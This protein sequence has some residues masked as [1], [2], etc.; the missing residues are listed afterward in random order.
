MPVPE[1][2]V[3]GTIHTLDPA[4]PRAGA[5]LLR[6]GRIACVGTEG[7]C[8]ARA[9][10][11]ARR[12]ELGGGS[13]I[14]GLADAHGHVLWLGRAAFEVSCEGSASAE[15]CAALVAARAA[16]TAEGRWIV[17]RGWD[18][19]RWPGAAFPD[20]A[21]LSRAAP[22]HPAFLTRVDGH[23]AWVNR[24]ALEAA[25]IAPGT[26]DPP[27][28][29]IGRD[30]AGRPDG[31]LIDAAMDLVRA[32]LPRPA[33]AELEEGLLAG[34]RAVAA[35]GL[36]SVHDAGCAPEVLDAY[37]RLAAAD[38]LPVRVYA[39]IDGMVPL[40]ALE[41]EMSR[42]RAAPATGLLEIRGVKLYADGA[43][44]SRGAAL[45]E[46]YS[47]DPGNRGLLVS[48]PEALREKVLACVR[49]G[50]QPAV[51][52]IGDRA[53]REALLALRAAG[54]AARA[55]RP[56]IEHL[57]VVQPAD[58]PLLAETGAVASV[59]PVQA[60]SDGPWA[61]ARLGAGS[62]RLAGAYAFRTLADSGA[63]LAFGSDFPVESP[64]PRAGLHAAETRMTSE[65]RPFAVEQAVSRLEA[66]RAFT[67]GAAYASFA[68]G[69][70]GRIAAGLDADLTL[71]AEDVL[72]VAPGA[73]RRLTVT[74]A[75]VAGRVAY[76]RGR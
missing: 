27:G 3:V 56:R 34:L 48:T 20:A 8:A 60:A 64:D 21:L 17:G 66:L 42:W 33:P 39:M 22:R 6:D 68:E 49:A 40:P 19:H 47:D 1:L 29:R 30:A 57:Q 2:L 73:L 54:S 69:R 13:A 71:F 62:V 15:A 23:A 14:P 44:G 63:V 53:V 16:A 75:L 9:A 51:H 26:P 7:K 43:L 59:Q 38:R 31:I 4:R 55:L 41:R 76:E 32:R 24:L 67:A 58:L 12:I 37:G 5:A 45:L 50:F 46:D 65:G 74:H 36:T 11:G 18:Q 52:A 72:A 10:P 61:A 70:R 28:G 25:G 35:L